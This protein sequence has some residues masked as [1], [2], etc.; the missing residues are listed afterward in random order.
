[1]KYHKYIHHVRNTKANQRAS[2]P[3]EI[4]KRDPDS[5][6]DLKYVSDPSNPSKPILTMR[7]V[8]AI[9]KRNL[10]PGI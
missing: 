10:Y 2:F 1:M 8:R 3:E 7:M 5:H 4:L 9:A 6:P